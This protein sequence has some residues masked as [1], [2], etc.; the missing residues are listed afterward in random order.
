M[1][2]LQTARSKLRQA[3]TSSEL[4]AAAQLGSSQTPLKSPKTK[5]KPSFIENRAARNSGNE[6][7]TKKG[8]FVPKKSFKFHICS[9][10]N[11]CKTIN[12]E[13]RQDI[14][15]K[16]WGMQSWQAQSNFILSATVISNPK[17]MTTPLSR[18]QKSRSFYF[19][20]KRVCKTVFLNT[21]GITNKRLDYCLNKKSSSKFC[22][23]DK[24]GK[25]TPNK[26]SNSK[27]KH[28]R[29]F[30]DSIPKYKSHYTQSDKVYFHE[31]LTRPMMYQKYKEREDENCRQSVSKPI[32]YK[33]FKQYN[34][35]IYVPKTD[36]CQQCDA[37]A[38]K[39]S[40]VNDHDKKKLELELQ[41][42]LTR[43]QRARAELIAATEE[44]KATKSVLTFTFDMQKT[45]LSQDLTHRLYFTNV[46]FGSTMLGPT[47]AETIKAI[48]QCGL[49]MRAKEDQKKYVHQ[50]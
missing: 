33:V 49:K 34:I 42:H 8:K 18:K 6:Y 37:G 40:I 48:W 45:N 36:T 39:L 38:I 20:T 5:K 28:I 15:D 23:P 32:F 50:Y 1:T 21:L 35:G 19:H 31:D 24:R 44:A 10:T 30:L 12:F 27:T 46:N 2:G 22:S 4:P 25:I 11:D 13:E 26:T 14:F 43:A 17:R 41:G 47:H 29:E 16:Y 7:F 9:C 3:S